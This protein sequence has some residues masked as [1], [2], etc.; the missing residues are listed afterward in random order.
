[1]YILNGKTYTKENVCKGIEK[2]LI[3]LS[4]EI[5][6]LINDVSWQIHN[7]LMQCEELYS[8]D[9]SQIP[10]H[11]PPEMK[12]IFKELKAN[13]NHNMS[14]RELEFLKIETYKSPYLLVEDINENLKNLP[15]LKKEIKNTIEKSNN[16]HPEFGIQFLETSKV[17]LYHSVDIIDR[18]LEINKQ[19]I[20]AKEND[21]DQQF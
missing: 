9:A 17:L 10:A 15:A 5:Q 21:N 2:E 4:N 8:P 1:M 19:I 12:K 7:L 20:R 14:E 18:E 13:L 11:F 6:L 3:N 16:M